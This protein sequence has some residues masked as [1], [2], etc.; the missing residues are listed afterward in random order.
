MSDLK[1]KINTY[2]QVIDLNAQFP[3]ADCLWWS[4]TFWI[5]TRPQASQG[6][7]ELIDNPETPNWI[8]IFGKDQLL[9]KINNI[10]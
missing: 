8:R 4:G 2:I 3:E 5:I 6:L 7:Q 1:T 10:N 9:Q